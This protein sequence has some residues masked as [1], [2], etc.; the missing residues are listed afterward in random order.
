M[1][2]TVATYASPSLNQSPVRG[3]AP[4][5]AV[6]PT[7]AAPPTN[8]R[9]PAPT[10]IR[11]A[12]T[13][14]LAPAAMSALIEAQEHMAAS[15][16]LLERVHTAQTIDRLISR[17]ADGDPPPPPTADAPFMVRRLEAAREQLA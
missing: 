7:P 13:V 15:V 1:F 9:P 10:P 5:R 4:T 11:S 3:P 8:D 2:A 6:A 12:S 14:A 16:S 17:L